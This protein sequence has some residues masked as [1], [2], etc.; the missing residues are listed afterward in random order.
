MF[1]IDS[2]EVA[3]DRIIARSFS[4]ALTSI[5]RRAT[6]PAIPI[7]ITAI[8]WILAN[9]SARS[10]TLPNDVDALSKALSNWASFRSVLES[11]FELATVFVVI[12]VAAE[13]VVVLLEFRKDRHEYLEAIALWR[14]KENGPPRKPVLW[15]V[16]VAMLAAIF[17][18]GGVAGEFWYEVGIGNANTCI[19]KADNSRA[20]LLEHEA[21]SASSSAIK[22]QTA[23]GKAG[24]EADA[25]G[26]KTAVVSQE[27][28]QI[29]RTL[30]M[31]LYLMSARR[32]RDPQSLTNALRQY[33]GRSV[34]LTSY[35]GNEEGWGLCTQLWYIAHGAK[36][37]A[38][39]RC[40]EARLTP[41]LIVPLTVFGPDLNEDVKIGGLLARQG[42]GAVSGV[43]A[44]SLTIFVGAKSPFMF[45][46]TAQTRDV[47]SRA[48]AAKKR[49]SPK[50]KR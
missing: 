37:D 38:V 26:I 25:V 1:A 41:E 43:K 12:G 39:N 45:G 6:I 47:E 48:A 11:R 10:C 29:N 42:I 30:G 4:L 23:A 49:R 24:R 22:A 3:P 16:I 27:A 44:T 13:V 7:V 34:T 2:F 31:A 18:F 35:I 19:Q 33:S 36:M 32:V 40:G 28:E 17:V 20:T 15:H 9:N 14:S 50:A 21:G 46:A 8:S 5:T